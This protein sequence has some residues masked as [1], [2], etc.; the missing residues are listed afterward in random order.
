MLG[1]VTHYDPL[2][3][4][5]VKGVAMRGYLRLRRGF[6]S[7]TMNSHLHGIPS[8]Q[9][10]YAC[11]EASFLRQVQG[12]AAGCHRRCHG[13]HGPKGKEEGQTEE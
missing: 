5:N 7:A 1:T 8:L 9:S 6:V 11:A 3:N 12:V 2:T 4:R 13:R 10:I